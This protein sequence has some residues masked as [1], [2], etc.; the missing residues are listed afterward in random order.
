MKNQNR[1]ILLLV[2]ILAIG[3]SAYLFIFP[4]FET[5]EFDQ[6]VIENISKGV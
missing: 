5:T 6:K 1:Y 3:L 2:A 4:N